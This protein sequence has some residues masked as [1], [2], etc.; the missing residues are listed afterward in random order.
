[1]SKF[2]VDLGEV[3]LS[4]EHLQNINSAIQKAVAG[5]L[6]RISPEKQIILI[7]VNPRPGPKHGPIIC[8]I[9]AR[10]PGLDGLKQLG[11]GS[12]GGFAEF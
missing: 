2:T 9:I 4:A 7:P 3:K 10:E 12:S 11:V 5:E 1:M 8:G 6:A